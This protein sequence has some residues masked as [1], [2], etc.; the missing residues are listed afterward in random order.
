MVF[1]EYMQISGEVLSRAPFLNWFCLFVLLFSVY[2]V[3]HTYFSISSM[4][5][6]HI[7]QTRSLVIIAGI[8][9]TVFSN[10]ICKLIIWN[11]YNGKEYN[12]YCLPFQLTKSKQLSVVLFL[13]S[14][15]IANTVLMAI[16]IIFQVRQMQYIRKHVK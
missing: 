10:G 13:A 16:Y 8:W 1:L 5:Q 12:Y 6:S 9:I 11:I 14:I 2:L 7:R 15:I 4:A 3:I